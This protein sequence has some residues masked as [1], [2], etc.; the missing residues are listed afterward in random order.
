M[1]TQ[2]RPRLGRDGFVRLAGPWISTGITVGLFVLAVA[3]RW[4]ALPD[5][6]HEMWGDEAQ[7]MVFARSF[8]QGVY[9]TPFMVDP[10][11][12]PALYDLALSIP[13]RL[14]GMDVTV[15]RGF[16]G[17]LGALSV[18][19][20]YLTAV[21]LGYPR[22]VGLIAG[23]ALATTFWDVSFSRVVLPNIMAVTATSV[24]LWLVVLA[25]RRVNWPL[26][27][28]A[29]VAL[30][31]D[32]NAHLSGMIATV[33]IVGWVVLLVVAYSQW[34]Q[35]HP[36]ASPPIHEGGTAASL[37]ARPGLPWRR[38]LRNHRS[39]PSLNSRRAR[40]PLFEML[41]LGATFGVVALICAWPLL[42]LY[43]S[44]GNGIHDHAAERYILSS[45]NRLAFASEHPDIGSGVLGI[46]WYQFKAAIGMFT[47][48][49]EPGGIGAVF[50]LNGRPLL[51]PLCSIFFIIG[52]VLLLW[53]WRRPAAALI[54]LWLAVP[55]FLGTMMT[56]GTLPGEDPPSFHRSIAAAPAM[57]LC[58]GLGA[59]VVLTALFGA[60]SRALPRSGS[61]SLWLALRPAAV[62]VIAVAISVIGVQR[63][64][65]FADAPETRLAF[66]VPAHEWALFL[67][68]RGV[69]Q[70][71]SVSPRGWPNEYVSL[72]APRALVC[73]GLWVS[74][75][76][77]CPP[78]QL[79]IF[80]SD[81][82]DAQ[83]YTALT[84]LATHP[85]PS[86]DITVRFWYAEGHNLPDPAHVLAG[87]P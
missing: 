43:F 18:P 32:A 5:H 83:R 7:F 69:I 13:L 47:V 86:D 4:W 1:V 80:D 84:H 17:V 44:P 54:L 28:L 72:Y 42:Q 77:A 81:E 35:R 74:T 60:L 9:T 2:G 73:T 57:C 10:R 25:V 23:V 19:L 39:L 66:R 24:T 11:G 51:D 3:V 46:L 38:R 40:L 31:W 52:V 78:S 85:G 16:D 30:A 65:A 58:I 79:I 14:A 64:W 21:E 45:A 56:P 12:L 62:A 75:W 15:A 49:G 87:L 50:N 41:A 37:K 71:T 34:W 67:A 33:F 76:Q 59:D 26:A 53:S 22:R 55:V 82:A 68:P 61:E 27:A 48:R 8:I 6:T 70:V 63:Y 29:G 20:L 36:D